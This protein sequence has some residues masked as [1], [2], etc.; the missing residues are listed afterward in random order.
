MAGRCDGFSDDFSAFWRF[1]SVLRQLG[2]TFSRLDAVTMNLREAVMA[3]SQQWISGGFLAVLLGAIVVLTG[4]ASPASLQP[5]E[6]TVVAQ[7]NA[8]RA[9]NGLPPLAVDPSLM[10]RARNHARWMAGSQNL[11]HG[12]GVAENIAMGQ[13]SASEAVSSWMNSSGH[14]SNM[15]DGGH[16]RIGVGVAYSSNGTAYWCQQFR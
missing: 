10:N 2:C 16:T 12:S 13:T 1:F 7:T 9:R 6:A 11:A 4:G 15:L 3:R 8:A 14:R 5:T